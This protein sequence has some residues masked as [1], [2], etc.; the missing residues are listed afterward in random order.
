MS[1][2]GVLGSIVR[3][4]V[5]WGLGLLALTLP[6]VAQADRIVARAFLEDPSGRMT[7]ADVQS[8]PA[9]AFT[10]VLN[11]GYSDSVYWIRLSLAPGARP[12]AGSRRIDD[13]L[14]LRI[15][16]TYLDEIELFDPLEPG[17]ARRVTGDAH[18]PSGDEFRSLNLGF[19]VPAGDAPRDLWLRLDSTSNFIFHVEALTLAEALH[20]DRVQE[21]VFGSYLAIVGLFFLWALTHWWIGREPVIGL[22]AIK[23]GG[24]LLFTLTVL[25]YLR[26][27]LGDALGGTTVNHLSSAIF[28]GFPPITLWFFYRLLREFAVPRWAV[29]ILAVPLVALPI[30]LALVAMGHLTWAL[31]VNMSAVVLGSVLCLVVACVARGWDDP[32]RG[33]RPLL[34]KRVLVTAHALVAL[35]AMGVAL[36]ALG[37]TRSVEWTFMMPAL[38]GL[39]SGGAI[40]ALLHVRARRRDQRQRE[41]EQRLRLAEQRAEDEHA[42]RQRQSRFIDMLAHEIKTALSVIRMAMGG[43]DANAARQRGA[44]ERAV[45]DMNDVIDRCLEVSRLEAGR[46]GTEA[47]EVALPAL[48]ADE[49]ARSRQPSR[50]VIEA[51]MSA[52]VHSDARVLRVILGNLIDNALKYSPAHEV[53]EVRA[54]S[55]WR[56]GRAGTEI[57]VAN[58]PGAAGWPDAAQ[59]FSRYYRAP[60]ARRFTG[61]GLGLHLAAGLCRLIGAGLHYEP[62]AGQVRFC[63]WLPQ[64]ESN[65]AAQPPA[66]AAAPVPRIGARP[67][68]Q[69]A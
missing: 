13:R 68:G 33:Q 69:P 54:A 34:S 10:G 48:L 25:G 21:L 56:E 44:I 62:S 42:E 29:A 15:R 27:F 55:A 19:V 37:L 17:G 47:G 41:A 12:D 49:R 51:S 36:P 23:Q 11:Q 31:A 8:R 28:M 53:I 67:E 32:A 14:V 18:P 58:T 5:A 64:A 6:T 16:P 22:F 38:F 24:M 26:D 61:S 3:A 45:I 50:V 9:Q 35:S 4:A 60:G 46:I 39:I 66:P 63:V 1:F 65:S 59:L 7:L 52:P 20:K 40:V 43:A 2:N 57:V 30:E